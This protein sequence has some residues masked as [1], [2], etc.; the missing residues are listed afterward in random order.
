MKVGSLV[1]IKRM[2]FKPLIGVGDNGK[3][4]QIDWIP[5]DDEETIYTI[6]GL[7]SSGVAVCFEE[8]TIGTWS[9]GTEVFLD[10]VFVREVQPPMKIS[11][12]ELIEECVCVI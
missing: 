1:V 12:E 9:D 11:V 4:F 6:R 5:V 7:N 8:G 10:K 3:S 2:F